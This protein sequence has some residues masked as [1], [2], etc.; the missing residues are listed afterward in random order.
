MNR[1]GFGVTTVHQL[2]FFWKQN[3]STNVFVA[4]S[5][6]FWSDCGSQARIERANMDGHERVQLVTRDVIWPNG[7]T[8]DAGAGRV[9]WTDAR[10]MVRQLSFT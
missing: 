3:I 10:F 5:L 4:F 9:Y 7:V 1:G 8:V 6:M 2:Q